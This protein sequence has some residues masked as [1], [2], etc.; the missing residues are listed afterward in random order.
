MA[1][2]VFTRCGFWPYPLGT[3]YILFVYI[4]PTKYTSIYS[5]L[6]SSAYE[7]GPIC[8]ELSA[9]QTYYIGEVIRK[10]AF[11]AVF[12]ALDQFSFFPFSFLPFF[13]FF[14]TLS[15]IP[16]YW[17]DVGSSRHT[18]TGARMQQ[19]KISRRRRKC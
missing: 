1:A 17:A 10:P 7:K 4:V 11:L 13:L 2:W 9:G 3:L 14:W 16:V 5:F 12:T 15:L 8:V 18:H 6:S 19:Q